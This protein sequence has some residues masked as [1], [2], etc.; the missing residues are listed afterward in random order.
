MGR[1]DFAPWVI[2]LRAS[3]ESLKH[4]HLALQYQ[5]VLAHGF[6]GAGERER[7]ST[8]S[9]EILGRTPI[10]FVRSNKRHAFIRWYTFR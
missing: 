1:W 5:I 10:H 9:N 7:V 8:S 2:M 4:N 3:L 6:V